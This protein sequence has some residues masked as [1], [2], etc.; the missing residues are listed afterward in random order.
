MILFNVTHVLHFVHSI[1]PENG[2][3]AEAVVSLNRHLN[4]IG[5]HSEVTDN[6][7]F[8]TSKSAVIVAHGLWQWPSAQAYLHFKQN[9]IPY[10]LF[11][12]GMLDPWFKKAYRLKHLKKQI[13]WWCKESKFINNAKALCFTTEEESFLARKT[14]WPYSCN[15][16]ITGLGVKDPPN[17]VTEQCATFLS[18]YPKLRD[19]KVLL[20]LGRFHPKK[21]V[22]LL[23]NSFSRK[24]SKDEVLVLAG[25]IDKSDKHLIYLQNLAKKLPQ[26]II[27]TGM[28]DGD[29]KWGALRCADALILPSHQENYGMVVA[30]ALS[31]ETPVFLT[32]KVNLWREVIDSNC[33]IVAQNDQ[34]GINSLIEKWS[35]NEHAKM[36]SNAGLC[37]KSKLHIQKTAK[38]ICKVLE[39]DIP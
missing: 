36:H 35:R 16:V 4:T 14:F 30:E 6:P 2:G 39:L 27:W 7:K 34:H 5:V 25:P 22:D 18:E 28:L 15:E 11:P 12:H 9:D 13:Y 31:V 19:K 24:S 10:V 38:N 20:Y 29:L 26:K 17:N 8:L 3:V 33:G 21:G 37:F 23:I 32:N 1:N